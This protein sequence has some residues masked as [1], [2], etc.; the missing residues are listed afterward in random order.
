VNAP[1]NILETEKTL[2]TLS[3][4]QIHKKTRKT[5]NKKKN[6]WAGFF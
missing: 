4:G 1:K 3:S 2:K 6:H 5:K